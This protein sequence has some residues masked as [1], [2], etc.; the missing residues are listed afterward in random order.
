[1][2]EAGLIASRFDSGEAGEW[3]QLLGAIP[4][5]LP[6]PEKLVAA[7]VSNIHTVGDPQF[8]LWHIGE[9]LGQA[10]RLDA[11][12]AIS[13]RSA[14]LEQGLRQWRARLGEIDAARLLLSEMIE[15]LR[16]G[17]S[18]DWD[19]PDWVEGIVDPA[20]LPQLFDALRADLE[21][22]RDDPFGPSRA[23]LRAILR[24]GGEEAVRRYD[25]LIFSSE[26]SRFKFLRLHREDVIQSEL[27]RVGQ[28]R[29]PDVA[30]S[31]GVPVLELEEG[32][33]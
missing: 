17:Q 9:R 1:M 33:V 7:A 15:G 23:L 4:S 29:A 19:D 26:E 22:Q 30:A 11:L 31:L 8:G 2:P 12:Q 25:E 14:E 20:L 16:A 10:G 3:G 13:S 27:R 21:A 32:H 24:I 18:R 5:D 28:L 6:V